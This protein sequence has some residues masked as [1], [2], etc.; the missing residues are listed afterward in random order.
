LPGIGQ[1]SYD[2]DVIRADIERTRGD[3]SRDVNALGEAVSPSNVAKRQASKVGEKVSGAATS[4]KERVMGTADDMGSTDSGGAS[5]LGDRASGMA[6]DVGDR[7]S[8][9]THTAK[10]KTQGNPLAA[11]VIALGAGWLLGSLMPASE[12]ERA[13]ASAVKEKAQPV[14]QEAQSVAKEAAENL[15][16]PARESLESVKGTAQDAVATVKSEGQWAAEDVKGSAQDAKDTVQE[17]AGNG[18]GG[19]SGQ[20]A[21]TGYTRGNTPG[22]IGS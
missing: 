8:D 16:E 4:V 7:A 15:K 21:H 19:S 14:V 3:L 20:G 22:T 11:G 5:G 13:A 10:R 6:S 12:K 2:P 9:V 1:S 18:S 17:Q